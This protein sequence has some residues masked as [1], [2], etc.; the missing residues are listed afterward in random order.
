VDTD[1]LA[2]KVRAGF[3]VDAMA[4]TIL[5]QLNPTSLAVA[6]DGP[7]AEPGADELAGEAGDRPQELPEEVLRLL[8]S[9]QADYERWRD[10]WIK[11]RADLDVS[12]ADFAERYGV[13][14]RTVQRLRLVGSHGLLDGPIP[15]SS[16][17]AH[18]GNGYT[19]IVSSAR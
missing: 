8:P 19:P 1:A 13:S 16:Q 7:D 2:A 4:A 12:N 10:M 5:T 17:P 11:L 14:V 18:S 3:D 15:L 9:K 6:V